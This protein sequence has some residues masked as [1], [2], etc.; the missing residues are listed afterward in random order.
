MIIQFTIYID[1]ENL[2]ENP[3]YNNQYNFDKVDWKQFKIDLINA[4]NIDEFQ[5]HFD[6]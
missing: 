5:T 1:N 6:K 3:L 4:A 2:I